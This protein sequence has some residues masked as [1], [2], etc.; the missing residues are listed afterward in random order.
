MDTN[1]WLERWENK[2]FGFH[3]ERIN[4]C[5]QRFWPTLLPGSSNRVFV[6]LCGKSDDMRWLLEQG[7]YVVGSEL[8]SLAVE[9]FFAESRLSPEIWQESRYTRWKHDNIEILCG[10]FFSLNSADVGTI[11]AFYDRASLIALTPAQRPLYAKQ[12]AELVSKHTTG[13]LITLDYNQHE[14][15]GPPFAVSREEV[16]CLFSDSFEIKQVLS[17]DVLEENPK[18]SEKGLTALSE[19][20]YLLKRR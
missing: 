11:D 17:A 10:D 12:L 2:Q 13:L 3:Q 8:S 15:N 4:P 14:I 6:P 18:F 20:A 16:D 5:L 19:N 1:F 7:Y 9:A